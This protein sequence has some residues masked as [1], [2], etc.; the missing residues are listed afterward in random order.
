MLGNIEFLDPIGYFWLKSD[1]FDL[2]SLLLM[3]F[4]AFDVFFSR[5]EML[6]NQLFST[7]LN[8]PWPF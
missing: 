8:L 2:C 6:Q 7:I 5:T 4:S 3:E 1:A